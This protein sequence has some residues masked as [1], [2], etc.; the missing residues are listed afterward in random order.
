ELR[1]LQ[2]TLTGLGLQLAIV[3]ACTLV[4][5]SLSSLVAT[6]VAQPIRLRLQHRVQCLLDSSP[7][8]PTEMLTHPIVVDPDHIA[9][10]SSFAILF[11]GGSCP[12]GFVGCLRKHQ[13]NQSEGHR[14]M[15]E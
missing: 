6:R 7:H 11:H 14:P 8:D 15:C 9:Q 3:A 10:L 13:P 5:A 1:H 12:S 4:A 2:P